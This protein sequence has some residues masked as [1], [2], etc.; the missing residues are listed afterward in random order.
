MSTHRFLSIAALVLMFASVGPH[1]PPAFARKEMLRS[2]SVCVFPLP[3]NARELDHDYPGGLAPRE[4]KYRFSIQFDSNDPVPVPATETVLVD[5][6]NSVL[7][8]L[9]IIRDGDQIIESFWF[10]F[11]ERGSIHLCLRYQPW[12][13]TWSLDPPRSGDK[14]CILRKKAK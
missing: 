3:R 14:Q 9:V 7:R 2:G 8:H 13:Q 11:R 5:G 4:F 10:T 1:E 6:L 12:Y